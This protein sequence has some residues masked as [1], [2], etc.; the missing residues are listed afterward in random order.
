VEAEEYRNGSTCG[1]D[2]PSHPLEVRTVD[3]SL[4]EFVEKLDKLQEEYG[5]SLTLSQGD[6]DIHEG[7]KLVG[8]WCQNEV[9]A[10]NL[11]NLTKPHQNK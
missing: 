1:P 9:K 4:T 2:C 3:A 6:L 8:Y 7:A 5:Y 11:I 10:E